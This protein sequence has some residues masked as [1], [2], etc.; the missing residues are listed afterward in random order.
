MSSCRVLQPFDH[1]PTS[2]RQAFPNN[3]FSCDLAVPYWRNRQ[4]CEFG[5]NR[6]YVLKA[7]R[8]VVTQHFSNDASPAFWDVRKPFQSV[9]KPAVDNLPAWL[10]CALVP[11]VT[12][13]EAEHGHAKCPDVALFTGAVPMPDFVGEMVDVDVASDIGIAKDQVVRNQTEVTNFYFPM[14]IYKDVPRFQI[15]VEHLP[16]VQCA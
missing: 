6:A 12:V 11:I 4:A 3:S 10:W 5:L 7:C 2:F 1:D 14:L 15:S 8:C 13:K 9:R 16:R